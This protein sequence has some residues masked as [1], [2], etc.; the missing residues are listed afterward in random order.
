M[1]PNRIDKL[2]HKR[3][4]RHWQ[5]AA[6]QAGQADLLTLRRKRDDAR[7][8][9]HELRRFLNVAEGRLRLP[10]RGTNAIERPI[11]T[12]W[13]WRPEIWRGPLAPPGIAAVGNGVSYGDEARIFH[14][15]PR[16]EIILR[17]VRNDGCEDVLAPFGLRLEAFAFEGSF[18]SLA[19]DLPV[20][21]L[22][23]LEKDHVF[24]VTIDRM[25]ER[26]IE[27]F[28]RLNIRHG[29]NTEQL[30]REM[31]PGAGDGMVEYDLAYSRI[32]EKRVEK[33][34]LDV[35][36]EN[37]QFNRIHLRDLTVVRRVRAEI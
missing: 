5:Q 33:I 15:C 9:E 29:P 14:D 31:P 16:S 1:M 22:G 2:M 8:L 6:R 32:N 12:D 18:L 36:F 24:R 20:E 34:W 3:F 7:A 27:I 35:I 23:G 17:Q 26:D 25:T 28:I 19:L 21:S 13:A 37:P 11:G 10:L 4:L 30:V